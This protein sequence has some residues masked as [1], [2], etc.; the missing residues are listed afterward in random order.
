DGSRALRMYDRA[1]ALAGTEGRELPEDSRLER[2]RLMST[3][4]SRQDEALEEFRALRESTRS[5]RI[6]AR[7]LAVW[8][9]MR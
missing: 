4:R 8:T 5:D 1:R 3:V 7:N 6:G 2:A 9:Q